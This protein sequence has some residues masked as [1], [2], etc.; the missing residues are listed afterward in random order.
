VTATESKAWVVPKRDVRDMKTHRHEKVICFP[1]Y[2]PPFVKHVKLLW[3]ASF[4]NESRQQPTRPAMIESTGD[5]SL[6]R[7]SITTGWEHLKLLFMQ[8]VR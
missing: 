7:I 1:K 8:L 4:E 6:S 2:T 5:R 3:D